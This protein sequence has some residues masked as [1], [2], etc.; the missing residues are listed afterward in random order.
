MKKGLEA[1]KAPFTHVLLTLLTLYI[2]LWSHRTGFFPRTLGSC[3]AGVV[4]GASLEMHC[5]GFLLNEH[6]GSLCLA[7]AVLWTP[8]EHRGQLKKPWWRSVCARA[9][10]TVGVLQHQVGFGQGWLFVR[11]AGLHFNYQKLTWVSLSKSLQF[12]I[13]ILMFKVISV[14]PVRVTSRPIMLW[15]PS[16]HFQHDRYSGFLSL[17]YPCVGIN[18]C[19]R[20]WSLAWQEWPCCYASGLHQSKHYLEIMTH[21]LMPLV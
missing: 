11:H 21:S 18:R 9:S 5:L 15:L 10:G 16:E 14:W 20:P 2:S 19:L 1:H 17:C 6:I 4:L 12:I 13:L 3:V 7:L 8:G